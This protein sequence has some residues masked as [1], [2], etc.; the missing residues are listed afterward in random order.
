MNILKNKIDV[1]I[2]PALLIIPVL[3]LTFFISCG[4]EREKEESRQER[5]ETNYASDKDAAIQ[6]Y[7]L[8]Q[9]KKQ[10]SRRFPCDT[11]AL[12]EFVLSH[13]PGGTYLVDFDKTLTYNIP[14]VG[15]NLP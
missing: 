13:Y 7:N 5:E 6:K 8:D 2:K 12:K 11:I 14:K 3:M 9:Q 10:V 4:S 1:I 15:S